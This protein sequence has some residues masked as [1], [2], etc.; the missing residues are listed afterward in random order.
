[1]GSLAYLCDRQ[2]DLFDLALDDGDQFGI[3]IVR[4][5]LLGLLRDG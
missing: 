3:T 1:M 4:H 2:G 5:N